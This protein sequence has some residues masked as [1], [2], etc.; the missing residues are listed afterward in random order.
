MAPIDEE[1]RAALAN[2]TPIVISGPSGAGKSTILKRL[3]EEFPDRFGFSV[4]RTFFLV[5]RQL[6][7]LCS[8]LRIR[9]RNDTEGSVC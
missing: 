6:K 8:T 1:A 4:S 5:F 7:C 3:F 2:N 9:S